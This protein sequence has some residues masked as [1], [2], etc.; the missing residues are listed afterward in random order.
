LTNFETML[1][2]K[3]ERGTDG[4]DGPRRNAEGWASWAVPRCKRPPALCAGVMPGGRT[5]RFFASLRMTGRGAIWYGTCDGPGKVVHE[6][7]QRA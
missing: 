2:I 3:G 5:T 6:W 4:C 7:T 1:L